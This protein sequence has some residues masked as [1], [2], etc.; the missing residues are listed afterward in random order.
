MM[1]EGESPPCLTGPTDPVI[2]SLPCSCRGRATRTRRTTRP[3]RRSSSRGRLS[4]A[5][6]CDVMCAAAIDDFGSYDPPP[7]R[8]SSPSHPHAPPHTTGAGAAAAAR[9]PRRPCASRRCSPPPSASCGCLS[10]SG[11]RT[12][13]C[14]RRSS[15]ATRRSSAPTR[16]ACVTTLRACMCVCEP[17]RPSLTPPSF[18]HPLH[19]KLTGEGPGGAGQG[20]GPAGLPAG[21]GEPGG[22]DRRQPRHRLVLRRARVLRR[23]AVVREPGPAGAGLHG[24]APQQGDGRGGHPLGRHGPHG[25]RHEGRE[26]PARVV[27]RHWRARDADPGVHMCARMS[28]LS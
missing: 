17:T 11:S 3:R 14:S 25:L 19:S 10:W 15:S 20:G 26:G 2:A 22:D 18:Q 12:S 28:G 13:C 5:Y 21:G 6:L 4:G 23:G 1:R 9:G 24:A 27:R 8:H 7:T 16:Y